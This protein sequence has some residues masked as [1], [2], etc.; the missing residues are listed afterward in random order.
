MRFS[1]PDAKAPLVVALSGG[2]DSSVAAWLLEREGRDL[3]GLFMRNGIKLDPAEVV[4]KSCCSLGDARDARMVAASMGFPFQA[5]DLAEEFGSIIDYFVSEYGRGRTPNPCA[6]CNRDLKMGRLMDFADEFGAAGVATGH[7]A[8]IEVRDGRVKLRRGVDQHKDQSYQLFSVSEEHLSRTVLPLGAYQKSE[9]RALATEAGLRTSA[10]KDS[11][12]VCFI[13][14]NNYR[15]LLA[16]RG[17]VLHPGKIVDV[18]GKVLADHPGTEHFT[19]GQRRGLGVATG[20]PI[21]VVELLPEEGL[22]VVGGH[23][24]GLAQSMHVEN[25]NWIGYDAPDS[26]ECTV[27]HRYHCHPEPCVVECSGDA[28]QVYLK[29]DVLAV[30]PGQGAA[31]YIDDQLVGGGWIARVKRSI[32]LPDESLEARLGG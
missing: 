11:Q 7:Y 14:S 6:V 26:F 29:D 3:V 25:L 4:K 13:P 5:V 23:E 31:F 9:V 19:I 8:Q 16:Q 32:D 18:Y 1:A 10:K 2:V 24:H 30:T 12:E 27:Q 21:F 17:T 20:K 15:E 22:V 28:A